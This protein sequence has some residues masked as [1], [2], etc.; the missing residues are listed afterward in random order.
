MVSLR[1]E[2]NGRSRRSLGNIAPPSAF[3][4]VQDVRG[5]W[6][7]GL[8]PE[9]RWRGRPFL[10]A[11]IRGAVFVIPIALAVGVATAVAPRVVPASIRM[12]TVA[13]WAISFGI[14]SAVLVV[15][16][17]GARRFLP[18]ALLLRLS[19]AFPDEAPSRL[20]VAR[21]AANT[22]DLSEMVAQAHAIGI[23]DPPTRSAEE[24]LSLVAAVEAHDRAT[25]GHSERVRIYTDLLAMELR[26]HPWAR[27]RLRWAALLHDVGKIA[28]PA[29]VLNKPAAL[30]AE[31]WERIRLHPDVGARLTRGLRAWLTPWG[32]AIEQH[33]E[34]YDG[35]GYPRGLAGD[36][37]AL[38]GR[39]VAVCDAFETMTAMRPY[40]KPLPAAKAREELVRCAGSHFDPVMVRAFLRVSV[41]RLSL[42]A[43]PLSWLA[44]TPILAGLERAAT[45]ARS[46]GGA[47]I[48]GGGLALTPVVPVLPNAAEPSAPR[49]PIS[50]IA[51]ST[52]RI[53]LAGPR[54]PTREDSPVPQERPSGDATQPPAPPRE[55][56]PDPPLDLLRLV[57]GVIPEA[58]WQDRGP[59]P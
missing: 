21:R 44:Q 23:D 40:R 25:R 32:A 10:S 2:R 18:L 36:E 28:I 16:N 59:L 13:Y 11:L 55:E 51:P 6:E 19:L 22:R 7:L 14:S 57:M 12:I 48:V 34:R 58:G 54:P 39:I 41:R 56:P 49:V 8:Q 53:S 45:A 24:I 26:L 27:D 31:E 5:A 37:I 35:T 33:H 42:V 4:A 46:A 17:R 52:G 30:D 29:A 50:A 43:G 47:A 9:H 38:G 20:R 1:C 3:L 15:V